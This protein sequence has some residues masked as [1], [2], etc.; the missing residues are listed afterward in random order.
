VR[1]KGIKI[2]INGKFDPTGVQLS[3]VDQTINARPMTDLELQ[4]DV[5]PTPVLSVG[6][7]IVLQD[8]KDGDRISVAFDDVISAS[9]MECK[10]ASLFGSN[11]APVLNARGCYY[12]HGGGPDKFPGETLAVQRL[13][14]ALTDQE[15]CTQALQRMNKREATLSPFITY[16]LSGSNGHQKLISSPVEVFPAWTQWLAAEIAAP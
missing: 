9:A 1:I 7:T 3:L 16:G 6:H 4:G 11:V 10:V 13:S 8:L 12:C 2:L 14:M 5:W 15:L